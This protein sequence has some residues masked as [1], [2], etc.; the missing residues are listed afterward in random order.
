[1]NLEQE[2]VEQFH[3]KFGAT[4]GETPELRDHL[5]AAKLILEEAV[6]TAAALGFHVAAIID[7][8]DLQENLAIFNKK[9][10]E[11][12]FEDAVDGLADTLYV[13]Y[14][15]AVRWGIDLQPFVTEVHRANMDKDGGATRADGKVLKPEGWR[16]PRIRTELKRQ[17]A[18]AALWAGTDGVIEPVA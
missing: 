7:T 2:M 5:L 14:G 15:A 3:E 8:P 10:E 18:E 6:E 17:I 4:I 9:Y 13:V 12:H 1:M 11:P 16:P